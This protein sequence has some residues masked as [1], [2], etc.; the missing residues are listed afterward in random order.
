MTRPL[1]CVVGLLLASS[2]GAAPPKLDFLYPGGA[3]QGDAVAVTLG[4]TLDPWP[5]AFWASH[6]GIA[7]EADPKKPGVVTLK[8]GRDVPLGTHWLRATNADGASGVRPFLVNQLAETAE[9]EPN[10]DYR[11]PNVVSLPTIVNG[12]LEKA[13]DVDVFGVTVKKGETLVA[14]VDALSSLRSPLDAVV[15]IV[16]AEGFVLA[17][18]DD[19]REMDPLVVWTAPSDSPVTVRVFGFPQ[20]ADSRIGFYGKEN[21]VYRL[22]LTTGPYVDHAWPLAVDGRTEAEVELIGWNLP[23]QRRAKVPAGE[24]D[25]WVQPPGFASGTLVRREPHAAA[26]LGPGAK[27]SPATPLTLSG[28]LSK[29]GER[30][31]IAIDAKK[32]TKASIRIEARDR[33]FPL[34]PV[35]TL[36]DPKGT[37]ANKTQSPKLNRDPPFDVSLAQDGVY[38]LE[39]RDLHDDGGPRHAFLLRLAAAGPECDGAT[40]TDRFTGPANKPLEIAV[41]LTRRGGHVAPVEIVAEGLPPSAKQETVGG[42]DAKKATL[43]LTGLPIGGWPVSLRVESAGRRSAVSATPAELGVPVTRLWISVT[44]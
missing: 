25:V 33:H 23:A 40:T 7:F 1:A 24:G 43:K 42:K 34:D 12:R 21:A 38:T 14:A 30:A 37:T 39:V 35:L 15:Q 26:L 20:V 28:K 2:V 19:F 9:K 16:S 13:S 18:N 8:V 10:D 29:P 31:T 36:V 4:G 44:K 3:R 41:D 6:P 17:Q 27:W 11:K 5:P 32:G 22:S